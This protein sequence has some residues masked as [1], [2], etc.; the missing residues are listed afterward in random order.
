MELVET[1]C[2][3]RISAHSAEELLTGKPWTEDGLTYFKLSAL[4]EYLKRCGFT[5]YTRGQITERLKE[6]NDGIEADKTDRF[7]D[8]QDRRK[9]VRVWFVPE[10]NRGEV[11]LPEVTFEPEDPP[12]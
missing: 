2:T 5:F 1:F 4:Q 7:K 3:S 9:S 11:D 6:M 10:M 12:F 8:N